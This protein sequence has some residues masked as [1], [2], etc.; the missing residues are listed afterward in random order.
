MVNQLRGCFIYSNAVKGSLVLIIMDYEFAK[1]I[2]ELSD[3]SYSNAHFIFTGFL[4]MSELS[5]FY[6]MTRLPSDS[7]YHIMPNTYSINGGYDNAQ[8]V[9]VRFGNAAELMYDEPFPIVCINI[10]P[11]MKKFS[12]NL[13]HRDFL[14]ALMNL[15]IERSLIGDILVKDN[16]CYIFV[17]EQIKEFIIKEL[18]RVKHTSVMAKELDSFDV[19]IEPETEDGVLNAASLRLDGFVAKLHKLSRNQAA[20]LFVESRVFINGR[21][22][23]NES[24][25]LKDGDS[26]VVR[27]FGRVDFLGSSGVTKKGNLILNYK[28][29]I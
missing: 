14:G 4:S 8:R 11:L 1:R 9:I 26:V 15:G 23:Q 7:K 13:T 27:G 18:T 3:R 19:K 24:Y 2:I 12:D 10:C 20:E 16:E 5:D 21:C 22:C 17:K 25:Q 6:D 28:K 29:Y